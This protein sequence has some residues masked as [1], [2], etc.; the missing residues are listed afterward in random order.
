MSSFDFDPKND[1]F[2]Q[3]KIG[4]IEKKMHE[5]LHL[6]IFSEPPQF[7]SGSLLKFFRPF[8][9]F[10]SLLPIKTFHKIDN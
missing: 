9:A 5:I 2:S 8:P 4:P 3:Q 6:P 1:I 7:S 10:S